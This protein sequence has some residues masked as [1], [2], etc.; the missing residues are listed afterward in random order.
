M[1]SS[2]QFLLVFFLLLLYFVTLDLT[3]QQSGK[4]W[5]K[6]WHLWPTLWFV[7]PNTLAFNLQHSQQAQLQQLSCFIIQQATVVK[8]MTLEA[9]RQLLRLEHL[10]GAPSAVDGR[11]GP[12]W[13]PPAF[14]TTRK[15]FFWA[16][17]AIFHLGCVY[18][19]FSLFFNI[20]HS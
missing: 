9:I 6:S 12:G 11:T 19:W 14:F 8:T 4:F 15:Y 3:R 10:N 5:N 13:W 1:T 20:G 16:K 7:T 2:T 18:I 17:C